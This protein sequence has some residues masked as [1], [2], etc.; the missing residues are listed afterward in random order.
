MLGNVKGIKIQALQPENQQFSNTQFAFGTNATNI[1]SPELEQ[2][3]LIPEAGPY[4]GIP[5][6]VFHMLYLIKSR[7]V[8]GLL[9]A[10]E[11]ADPSDP[12]TLI[13]NDEEYKK[14]ENEL[15]LEKERIRNI[16]DI[17]KSELF[18]C[19]SC[20]SDKV[21]IEQKQLRR[22]DEG[23]STLITCVGCGRHRRQD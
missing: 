21:K 19:T 14:N 23:V 15:K 12:M 7:G 17:I 9:K 5:E 18:K 3:K 16:P 8:V 11:I 6:L 20:G 10:I 13:Y 4:L 1:V 2:L 22:A